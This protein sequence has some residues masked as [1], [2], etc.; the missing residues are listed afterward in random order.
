MAD[1]SKTT[2]RQYLLVT[3]SHS[4]IRG[5]SPVEVC[6]RLQ[7]VF[8]CQSIIVSTERHKDGGSHYHVGLKTTSA[9]KNNYR[10]L[11]RSVFKEFEGRQCDVQCKKGWGPVCAYLLKEDKHPLVVGEYTVEQIREVAQAWEEKRKP[12]D[13]NKVFSALKGCRNWYDVYN[14]EEIRSIK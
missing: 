12:H 10:Q 4:E 2:L 8:E 5:V 11:V 3:L 1:L 13:N 6:N 9:S 14:N 7:S